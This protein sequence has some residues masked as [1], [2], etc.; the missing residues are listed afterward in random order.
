MA[1]KSKV[2]YERRGTVPR[3]GDKVVSLCQYE[4]FSLGRP[5]TVTSVDEDYVY[6]RVR[7]GDEG[8]ACAIGGRVR[9]DR[10]LFRLKLHKFDGPGCRILKRT[11][12][13][14]V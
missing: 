13:R 7:R 4:T 9:Y 2:K 12:K 1:T 5:H 14:E 10:N 8:D 11:E 6:T 3:K